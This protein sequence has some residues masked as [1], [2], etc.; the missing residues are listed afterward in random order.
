MH[1]RSDVLRRLCLAALLLIPALVAQKDLVDSVNKKRD[2]LA[3]RG[4]DVVAYFTDAKPTKGSPEFQMEWNGAKWQFANATHLQMFQANPE[5]YAPQYGGY[6]AWAVHKGYTADADPQ[7]WAI[8]GGKLYLNYNASVQKQ[9]Q[10]GAEE[11]I[12]AADQ[13]WPKLH[14]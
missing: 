13:N 9:W 5:K 2:G 1:T 3:V 14:R 8:V 12:Q 6:C 10:Q 4:Y 7:A 11:R